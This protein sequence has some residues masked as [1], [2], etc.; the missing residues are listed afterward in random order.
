M[1]RRCNNPNFR[2]YKDYGARGITVDPHWSDFETFVEDMGPKPTKHHTLDRVDNDGPYS[3][4]NCRW[5]T[6]EE[7]VE[8]SRKPGTYITFGG[9]RRSMRSWAELMN[10]PVTSVWRSAKEVG[11]RRALLD[12]IANQGPVYVD[13]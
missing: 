11:A 6:R 1:L 12:A 4:E 7:Q 5:A 2:Q 8:N 9:H 10:L 3:P 13:E